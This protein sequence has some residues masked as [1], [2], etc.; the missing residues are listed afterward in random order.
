[1]RILFL[2]PQPFYVERGTPIAVRRAVEALCQSGHR[3]DLVTFHSGQDIAIPGME[4][5][6]ISAPPGIKNVPVGFSAAKLICDALLAMKA[7]AALRARDYDVVHAVEEAVFIG[8]LLKRVA[9][10]KL[11]YDMDS[12]MGEQIIEK[13]GAL[14]PILPILNFFERAAIRGSD[15]VLA[16]CDAIAERAASSLPREQVHVL[17]DI[18]VAP[19]GDERAEEL[20]RAFDHAAPLALYVGNLEPY[21]GIDLALAALSELPPAGR[22]NLAVVG[23]T[24]S[25][26]RKYEA[27]AAELGLADNVRFLGPR[28]VADLGGYLRQAD[29]L[30]SPR[31]KGV[32][33]PMKVYSYMSAGR[34]ILATDIHSH[35]QVLNETCALLA[36]SDPRSMADALARLIGSPNL[37]KRLGAAAATRARERFDHSAFRRRLQRAYA[38]LGAVPTAPEPRRVSRKPVCPVTPP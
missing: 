29:I 22:C 23:G 27:M 26:C 17:P 36:A 28:P 16:V 5:M 13:W 7:F 8:L 25:A 38:T 6:R 32:N 2:A 34:A 3:V 15:L 37:R 1:M 30:L 35:R 9:R 19:S 33:T 21:Q 20:G 12:L 31:L 10:F 18:A 4:L 24:P 14:R 11:V